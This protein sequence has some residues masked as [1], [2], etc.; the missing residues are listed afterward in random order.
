MWNYQK[1]SYS[2]F[3]YNDI[4][5][6]MNFKVFKINKLKKKV[7][8]RSIKKANNLNVKFYYYSTRVNMMQK[9]KSKYIVF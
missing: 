3:N 1:K 6:I 9:L 4:I 2:Y 7:G 8:E 5:I